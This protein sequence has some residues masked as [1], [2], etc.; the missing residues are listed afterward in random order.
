MEQ[1][2]DLFLSP[3][4]AALDIQTVLDEK[5]LLSLHPHWFIEDP[6]ETDKALFVSLRDYDTEEE[7]SL[8]LRLDSAPDRDDPQGTTLIFRIT[9]YEYGVQEILFFT[10]QEKSRV[11]IRYRDEEPPPELVQ[12]MLLWIRGIQEYLRLYVQR[13]PRTL[14]FRVLMNRMVLQMNPSQ[15]KIC[16]M[17]AKITVVEIVVIL[18][19]VIGYVSFGQ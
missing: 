18:V 17:L 15:R 16:L 9:L 11:R 6:D 13:T 10:E 7:F 1:V 19:I 4:A 14:F 2:L 8:G 3:D 12:D 5:K